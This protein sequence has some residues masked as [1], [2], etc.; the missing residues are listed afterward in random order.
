MTNSERTLFTAVGGL[1]GLRRLSHAF[2]D[3]VVADELLAPLFANFT[4]THIDHVAVWLGEIFGGPAT[5]TERLGGHQALLTSHLGLNIQQ[6][7]R[8][9][10]LELMGKAIERELPDDPELRRQVSEYF[11]WGTAIAVDVSQSPVGTDLGEPG[12]TPRWGWKGLIKH[13]P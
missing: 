13:Q 6:E 10:W 8:T 3:Q 11:E 5:F 7:H 2:Y 4:P 12:P 1:D 9:R